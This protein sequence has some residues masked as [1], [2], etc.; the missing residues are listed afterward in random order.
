MEKCA[1]SSE[2]LNIQQVHKL[3]QEVAYLSQLTNMGVR[4]QCI[5]TI[6]ANIFQKIVQTLKNECPL[7]HHILENI[8]LVSTVERNTIK[9]NDQKMKMA[10]NLLMTGLLN[11]RNSRLQNDFAFLFGVL[12][13]SYGAGPAYLNMLQSL[14]ITVHWKTM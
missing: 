8:V 11:I 14:G 13:V 6:H 5:S 7:V 10:A 12:L 2:E 4:T 3:K 9:T 1:N